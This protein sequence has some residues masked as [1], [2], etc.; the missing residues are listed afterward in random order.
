MDPQVESNERWIDIVILFSTC[1]SVILLLIAV[2]KLLCGRGDLCTR[3]DDYEEI[4]EVLS[5]Q[6]GFV[7]PRLRMVPP[8][9][10]SPKHTATD[11]HAIYAEPAAR[12]GDEYMANSRIAQYQLGEPAAATLRHTSPTRT[13]VHVAPRPRTEGHR[14]VTIVAGTGGQAVRPVELTPLK[15]GEIDSG[16]ELE[17]SNHEFMHHG[18]HFDAGTWRVLRVRRGSC[19]ERQGTCG[20]GDII[21]SLNGLKIAESGSDAEVAARLRGKP[22]SSI[23]IEVIHVD[24]RH[25]MTR[26]VILAPSAADLGISSRGPVRR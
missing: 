7:S 23:A 8:F 18:L 17:R 10:E 11:A 6:L 21:C 19:C 12:W 15:D 24:C 3:S 20:P 5:P 9:A 26:Q 13:D 25:V 14:S 22:G 4:D 16:I 1:T 2:F